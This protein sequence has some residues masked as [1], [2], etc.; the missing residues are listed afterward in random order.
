MSVPV[1]DLNY[2]RAEAKHRA[3]VRDFDRGL[4][5]QRLMD[6]YRLTRRQI[7]RIL[8]AAGKVQKTGRPTKILDSD[9]PRVYLLISKKAESIDALAS[10]L[11][12]SASTLRRKVRE[13]GRTRYAASVERSGNGSDGNEH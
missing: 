2:S 10:K 13:Y 6:E 8:K 9:M 4:S 3:I 7:R 5:I 11:G 1:N 12:V